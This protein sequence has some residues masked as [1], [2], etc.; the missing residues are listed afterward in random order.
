[1]FNSLR[2]KE[3]N[4]FIDAKDHRVWSLRRKA[5]QNKPDFLELKSAAVKV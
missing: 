3:L 1:M 4:R 5:N 2:D